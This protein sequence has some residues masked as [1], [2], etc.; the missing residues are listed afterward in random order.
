MSGSVVAWIS[1]GTQIRMA[2]GAITFPQKPVSVDGC[3]PKW[4]M[5]FLSLTLASEEQKVPEAPF[6]LYRLSYMYYTGLGAVVAIVVGLV[7]SWATGCNKQKPH[8]DLISPVVQ[9]F[10]NFDNAKKPPK[11]LKLRTLA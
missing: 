5:E 9:P 8:K 11:V 7:V 1:I 2:Q 3:N 10:V 4:V 6:L